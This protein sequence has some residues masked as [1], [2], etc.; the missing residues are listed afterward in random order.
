MDLDQT[1]RACLIQA[2]P[3]EYDW[4]YYTSTAEAGFLIAVLDVGTIFEVKFQRVRAQN[5]SFRLVE[6][7]F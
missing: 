4:L 6:S 2:R 5:M 3:D 7:D 1:Y